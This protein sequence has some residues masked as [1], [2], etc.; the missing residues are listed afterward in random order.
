MTN[1]NS[2]S[3]QPKEID[4]AASKSLDTDFGSEGQ[5]AI[6]AEHNGPIKAPDAEGGAYVIP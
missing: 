4:D 5:E 6:G 1:P 2:N 3:E